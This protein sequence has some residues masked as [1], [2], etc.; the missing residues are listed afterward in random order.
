MNLIDIPTI[1]RQARALRAHELQDN[2]GLFT[3]SLKLYTVL[4]GSS[5][6]SLFSFVADCLR[7]AFSWNPQQPSEK[8]G[9]THLIRLNRLARRLFAWNPQAQNHC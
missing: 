7:P 1:E 2:R 3:D 8:T 4:L 6:L 5:I 9:A